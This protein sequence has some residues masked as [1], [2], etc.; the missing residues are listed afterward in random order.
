MLGVCCGD[1]GVLFERLNAK[2]IARKLTLP[3]Q[4]AGGEGIRSSS[5]CYNILYLFPHFS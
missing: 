4:G 3:A 2:G 5:L 1:D